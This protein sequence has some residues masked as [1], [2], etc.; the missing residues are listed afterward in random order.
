VHSIR[1]MNPYIDN[2]I[3]ALLSKSQITLFRVKYNIFT[4]VLAADKSSACLPV[5]WTDAGSF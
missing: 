2:E 1:N 3:L 4:Q 5:S